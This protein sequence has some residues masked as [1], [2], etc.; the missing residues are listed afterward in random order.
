MVRHL[1]QNLFSFG[2]LLVIAG[3]ASLAG[4]G[5]EEITNTPEDPMGGQ[6]FSPS[7]PGAPTESFEG[8]G[9]Q[10]LGAKPESQVRKELPRPRIYRIAGRLYAECEPTGIAVFRPS[11]RMW[12]YHK[13]TLV[14][15]HKL[16]ILTFS[17]IHRGPWGLRGDR[18][19]AGRFRP[20]GGVMDDVAVF[21]PSTGMW[22][23]D[24]DHDGTTDERSPRVGWGLREELPIAGDFDRDGFSDDVGTFR[25]S[26]RMWHYDY[27]HNGTSDASSGPFGPEQGRPFTGDFDR[28]GEDDDVGVFIPSTHTWD[29]DFD[30][31][32][33]S[34][35]WI[36][37]WG[38]AEDLPF[39]GDFDGDCK[40]DDVGVFR[41]SNR[42]WYFDF[43]HDGQTDAR[44]GPWGAAGDI[45][46]AVFHRY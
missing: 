26:T 34:D 39:A 13:I 8:L 14:G 2:F 15:R 11:T 17:L 6:I 22:Y 20:G 44:E 35:G 21:R 9:S 46:V 19:I 41:P 7:A 28:D 30:H 33:D 32:G 1:I 27:D 40:E 42:M 18:P 45:P 43:D 12:Y 24:Y 16:F 4:H 25:P 10:T 29:Y 36:G 5:V 37:P 3:S 31:D 38:F 23:Y